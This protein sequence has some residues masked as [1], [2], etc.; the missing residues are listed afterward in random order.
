MDA[1]IWVVA[2]DTMYKT[3]GKES[4][5]SYSALEVHVSSDPESS[6]FIKCQEHNRQRCKILA[7]TL[8]SLHLA[9][10]TRYLTNTMIV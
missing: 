7:C 9:I 1:I 3:N 6:M 4:Y 10:S 2:K 5:K 8:L